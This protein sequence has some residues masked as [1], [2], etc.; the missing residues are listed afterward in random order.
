MGLI[1]STTKINKRKEKS[2]RGAMTEVVPF[3]M[4]EAL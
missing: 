2:I 3:W 4:R 1:P